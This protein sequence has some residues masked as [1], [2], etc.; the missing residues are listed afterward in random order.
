MSRPPNHT[1]APLH[2]AFRH[3]AGVKKQAGIWWR[4]CTPRERRLLTTCAV[5]ITSVLCWTVGI[6]PAVDSI[7]KS[8]A[9][10]PMLH[11]DAARIDALI[12]EAQT[13][14]RRRSGRL[15]ADALPQALEA[16]LRRAGLAAATT[17][18]AAS[19]STTPVWEIS[20]TEANA[21]RIMEWLAAIPRLIQVRIGAVELARSRVDGRDRPGQVSGRIVLQMPMK[22]QP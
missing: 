19:G 1:A 9:L 22:E 16:S 21:A 13:L 4:G 2:G 12:L 15:E 8:R 5:L 6:K 14:Q 20:V 17:L 7:A 3:L 11:A 10:L 18:S